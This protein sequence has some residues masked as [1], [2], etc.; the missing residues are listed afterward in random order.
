MWIGDEHAWLRRRI[1]PGQAVGGVTQ[2]SAEDKRDR[3]LGSRWLDWLK[4]QAGYRLV[5]GSFRYEALDDNGLSYEDK[6]KLGLAAPY[7]ERMRAKVDEYART[8]NQEMLVDAF[9]YIL[10]ELESPSHEAAHFESLERHD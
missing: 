2:Q 10:L 1:D 7:Y 4:K 3:I 8:G 9:N 5:M 6:V